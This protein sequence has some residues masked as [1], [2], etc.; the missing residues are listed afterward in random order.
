MAQ[1]DKKSEAHEGSS[2][3]FSCTYWMHH[4]YVLLSVTEGS[5]RWFPDHR[6]GSDAASARVLR[7]PLGP[8]LRHSHGGRSVPSVVWQWESPLGH[9]STPTINC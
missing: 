4:A 1:M 6:D 3:Y 8:S 2:F 9:F 5:L 7:L